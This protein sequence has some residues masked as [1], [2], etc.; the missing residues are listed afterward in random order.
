MMTAVLIKDLA[1]TSKSL[2]TSAELNASIHYTPF[3]K[4]Q[5]RV[6]EKQVVLLCT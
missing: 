5:K 4:R 6:R 1:C 3:I 2:F